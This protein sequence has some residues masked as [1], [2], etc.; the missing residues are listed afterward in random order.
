MAVNQL[1][2]PQLA[3]SIGLNSTG[4]EKNSCFVYQNIDIK[5]RFAGSHDLLAQPLV[6]DTPDAASSGHLKRQGC[7]TGAS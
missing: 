3:A 2:K 1:W 4:Y 7:V 6:H 5:H